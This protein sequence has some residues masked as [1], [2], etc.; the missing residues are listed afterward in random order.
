MKVQWIWILLVLA[1]TGCNPESSEPLS[2]LIEEEETSEVPL[3]FPPKTSPNWETLSPSSLGWN[4]NE[5]DNLKTFLDQNNTK[6]FIILKDGKIATEWYFG[7]HTQN[8]SWYWA[9]AGKTLTAFAIGLAQEDGFL[10]IDDRSNSY[11]GNGWTNL[12]LE[13]E[14]LITIWHQL[15]MT[16]GMDDRFFDCI[17]PEC[18]RYVSDAGDRWSYHNG[19]YTLLQNVITEATDEPFADYLKRKVSDK[20]GMNGFW[21]STSGTNNVYFSNA[22]S[23]ARFGLFKFSQWHL[24]WGGNLKRFCIY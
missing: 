19:P 16:A 3:Y 23:M 14:N 21:F 1:L 5:E 20:I 9:S 6:A 2:D 11:L 17:S 8:T 4:T 24:G 12:S 22:R 7:D 15:T 18:L 13:K 10:T